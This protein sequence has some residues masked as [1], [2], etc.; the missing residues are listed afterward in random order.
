MPDFS[1]LLNSTAGQASRPKTLPAGD[2]PG[3]IKGH[4]LKEAPPGK[5]YSMFVRFHV[6][7]SAWPEGTDEA[8]TQEDKG[9]GRMGPIDLSKRQLRK[10]FYDNSLYRL[11]DFIRSCGVDP[12]GRSYAEVLPELHGATV[13]VAVSQYLNQQTNEYGN[14]IDKLVGVK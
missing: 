10:D 13:I 14:Q 8:D 2:F 6:G 3:I 11:D 4:E 12:A 7:L 5:D 1:K 9:Q